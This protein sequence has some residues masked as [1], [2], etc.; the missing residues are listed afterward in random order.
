M[1]VLVIDHVRSCLKYD[2][3]RRRLGAFSPPSWRRAVHGLSTAS[4]RRHMEQTNV[5]AKVVDRPGLDAIAEPLSTAVRGAYKAA[6]PAG[7]QAKNLMHGVPLGHPLHPVFTDIPI[8]AWTTALALDCCANGD[9]GMRRAATFAMGVGLAGAAASAVTGL[10]DWSETSGRS[11]REGLIHG[12]LNIAATALTAAAYVRRLRDD[13][14][15]GRV[16]AWSGYAIALGAAYLGGDLV[17]GHRLGVTHAV[18]DQPEEFTAIAASSDVAD[19]AMIRARKDS[20][21]VLLARQHGRL[22]G[23]AHP[24]SHLGGP[25]SEGTL[26][27]GSGVCPWHG[28][29][30]A[31]E[32]GAVINGPA[33]QN[34]PVLAVRERAGQIEVK[35]P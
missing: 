17:Y 31:L 3:A 14:A 32:D 7:Q 28:S 27:D 12:L 10:T 22:C 26:K 13:D 4:P 35:E 30:F 21:D 25:L 19:G 11:R 2:A 8:G 24:C 18:I 20:T 5:I 34:Q 16:C 29:E 15:D 6:G 33:T 1:V 23:L 9:A